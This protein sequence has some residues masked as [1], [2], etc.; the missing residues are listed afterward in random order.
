MWNPVKGV[1]AAIIPPAS[2]RVRTAGMYSRNTEEVFISSDQLEHGHNTV[3]TSIHEI[4]HHTSGA[5]D[6]EEA[7]NAEMTRI[8][9]LV[10]EATAKGYF[11]EFLGE[12]SFV[13]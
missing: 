8:A 12:S 3:D 5:E 10:V 1:H 2:D 13:W 9:G 6:G 4:A 7:H 11:D